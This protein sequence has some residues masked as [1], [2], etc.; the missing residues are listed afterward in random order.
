M[1]L[2]KRKLEGVRRIRRDGTTE[3]PGLPDGWY[4]GNSH[5]G[6]HGP[7]PTE[8]PLTNHEQH[9]TSAKS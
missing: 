5:L 1:Q 6:W 8:P 4:V 9:F 2:S 3:I 7:F